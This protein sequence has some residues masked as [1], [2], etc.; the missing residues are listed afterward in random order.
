MKTEMIRMQHPLVTTAQRRYNSH[1]RQFSIRFC[2]GAFACRDR[3]RGSVARSS[4]AATQEMENRGDPTHEYTSEERWSCRMARQL[5]M[6]FCHRMPKMN[7]CESR[8]GNRVRI[9][10][11][12]ALRTVVSSTSA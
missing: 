9:A 6:L 8:S 12:T 11:V 5:M 2:R 10:R 7:S 3:T 1:P 4:G